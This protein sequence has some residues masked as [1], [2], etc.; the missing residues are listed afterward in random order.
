[1]PFLVLGSLFILISLFVEKPKTNL[2]AVG[3]G[4]V[5]TYMFLKHLGY[6]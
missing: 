1:M 2:S 6:I 4:F 5:I 3:L